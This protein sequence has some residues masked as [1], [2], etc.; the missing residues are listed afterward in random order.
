VIRVVVADDEVLVR[1]GVR[2]ILDAHPDIEVVG[3]AEDGTQAVREVADLQPDIVLMDVRMAGM[4][5]IEATR[6]ITAANSTT[7]VLVL[8]T[9]DH[10]ELVYD[11]M[12]A[13][14]SA[15]LL[16]TTPPEQLVAALRTVTAGDSL[17]APVIT[18]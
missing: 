18:R 15:F 12:R 6:R 11:A 7:R 4:D 9:F 10:D 8:T 17:L 5:G 14:A 3:E 1:S 2:M 13:G 16:K